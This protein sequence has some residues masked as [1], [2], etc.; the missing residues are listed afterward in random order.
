VLLEKEEEKLHQADHIKD[1][2]RENSPDML[3]SI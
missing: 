1:S 3:K 2:P